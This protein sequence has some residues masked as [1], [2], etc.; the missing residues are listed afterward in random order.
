M[1]FERTW[2]RVGPLDFT[3]D[4]TAGGLITVADVGLIKVKSKV[5]VTAIG[6]PDLVLEVKK[7]LSPTQFLVGPVQNKNR[8]K[9]SKSLTDRTDISAYTTALSSQVVSTQQNKSRLKPEDVIQ[10][11][12]E[13]EPSVALRTMSVDQYGN[14]WRSDNPLPVTFTE[15][16]NIGAVEITDGDD[17]LAVNNDGSINVN[18]VQSSNGEL[19]NTYNSVSSVAN[20]VLTTIVSYTV[21]V[22]KIGFLYRAEVSGSNIAEYELL[23]N[24]AVEAKKRT[25]FG[26]SLNEEFEFGKGSGLE[27]SAGDQVTVRT[28]HNR[29]MTGDFEG[30]IEVLEI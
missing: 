25:Y 6:L 15:S 23:I 16:L 26:S 17:N 7:V 4:G 24:A 18:V 8:Q 14:P 2:E 10:A 9:G 12:Y 21:P 28:I 1:A 11:V 19:V 5:K 22:G 20:Q 13:Q 29:P 3:A 27:L 30:R